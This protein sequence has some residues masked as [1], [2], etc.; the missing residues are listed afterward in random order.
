MT[1]P[2]RVKVCNSYSSISGSHGIPFGVD[3]FF[4][5]MPMLSQA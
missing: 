5:P 1:L 4:N 2:S 3:V